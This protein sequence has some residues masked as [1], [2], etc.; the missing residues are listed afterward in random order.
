MFFENPT[1]ME[2]SLTWKHNDQRMVLLTYVEKEEMGRNFL[3][4]KFNIKAKT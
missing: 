3:G 1:S 2:E 4:T